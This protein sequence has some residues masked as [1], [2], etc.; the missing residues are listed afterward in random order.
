MIQVFELMSMILKLETKDQITRIPFSFP[1]FKISTRNLRVKTY[2][3]IITR[4]FRFSII[5][6]F[7]LR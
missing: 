5:I 7:N 3:E 2:H 6:I 1:S 4:I